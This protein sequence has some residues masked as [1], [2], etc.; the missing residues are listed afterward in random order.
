MISEQTRHTF[1]RSVQNV[2]LSKKSAI[3]H[4]LF[5]HIHETDELFCYRDFI[6]R[7][8][9]TPHVKFG[10]FFLHNGGI[11][12]QICRVYSYRASSQ[13]EHYRAFLLCDVQIENQTFCGYVEANYE[14]GCKSCG[15]GRQIENY[16][17][18]GT[19]LETLLLNSLP[20]QAF[21]FS[22]VL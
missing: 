7:D 18:I 21:C 4:N 9:H 3:I 20:P 8:F 17:Y 13:T 15:M 14:E 1:L 22:A 5:Q 10:A 2:R 12:K 6:R 16:M 11:E 19:S